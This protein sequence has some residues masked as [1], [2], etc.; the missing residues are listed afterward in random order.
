MKNITRDMHKIAQ[1]MQQDTVFMRI[2][3]LVTLFFLP[4]TFISPYDHEHGYCEMCPGS[5]EESIKSVQS[6]ALWFYL[7][8]TLPLM[9]FTLGLGMRCIGG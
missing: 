2:I 9:I 1:K 8:I 6:G 5:N 3:S 7:A 4:V